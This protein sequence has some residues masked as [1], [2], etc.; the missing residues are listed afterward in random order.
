MNSIKGILDWI[1]RYCARE[2][3]LPAWLIY[4]TYLLAQADKLKPEWAALVIP[5]AAYV[6]KRTPKKSDLEG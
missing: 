2:F 1:M 6:F 5:V 4:L 3:L